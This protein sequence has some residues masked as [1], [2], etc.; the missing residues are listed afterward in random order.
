[1]AWQG[2][3]KNKDVRDAT[4][5]ELREKCNATARKSLEVYLLL[6]VRLALM[7]TH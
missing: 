5:A 2:I 7:I 1:M 3:E 4:L 6:Q